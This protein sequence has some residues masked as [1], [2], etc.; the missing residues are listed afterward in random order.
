MRAFIIIVIIDLLFAA[1]ANAQPLFEL[2]DAKQSGIEFTNTVIETDSLHIMRYEYLYN[3]HGIG[4]GDFNNDGSPD[5]FISGNMVAPALYLNTGNFQFKNISAAAGIKY[6]NT[7]AT[8]VSIADVNGDSL[9]DIYVSHSGYYPENETKLSNELWINKGVVN[10]IPQFQEMA[11]E[12]GLDL[13][14]TQSTQAVFFDYDRDGDLDMF[15]VNHSNHTVNPFLNTRKVRS[16]PDMKHGNLLLRQDRDG[17]KIKFTDVT[18][19]AGIINNA[20]NFGLSAT[21]SDLNND[22]WPDIYTTSDYTET[23]CFYLN[24][25]N[26]T[27]TES[28]RKSFTHVSKYSMGS[29]IADYNN[30]GRPDVVTLDMLPEDNHRQKL[31]KGP[32]EYDQ[33]HLLIDSGYYHQQMR[34]M[35]HLNMGTDKDGVVRF[36]EIG[37]LA[38]ISNTDWSWAGLFADFDNDGWKDLLVTNGY[39]RDFTDLDFLKYTVADAQMESAKKGNF[40]FKTFDLVKKMPSNKLSSYV[41]RNNHDLRFEDVTKTWGL[42]DP[43][44]SNSAVYADLDN[45]GDL[46]IIIGRNNE[47]V[48]LY[49]NNA[50]KKSLRIK[51]VGSGYNTGA[52]GAKLVL[53]ANGEQQML[54]KYPVRGYQSSVSTELLFGLGS[55][56]QIDSLL[57]TWPDGNTSVYKNLVADS[58]Y[59]FKQAPG[60]KLTPAPVKQ[61]F[62]DVTSQ[63]GIS[64]RHI[65]NNFIDFK[66]EVLLPYQLSRDGPALAAADVNGDKLSD[67]FVG[68]AIGQEGMLYIQTADGR[69]NASPQT[70]WKDDAVSEDVNAIFFD[71]DGDGDNDLYV[72]SGGNEYEAGSPEYQDRLY[73][74]DGKGGFT[75]TVDALPVMTGSKNGVATGDYDGDGDMDLFVGGRCVAGSYPLPARSYLLQNKSANGKIVFEDVT[76]TVPALI[77]PGMISTAEWIDFDGDKFPE[78]VVSGD[79]MQVKLFKNNNG[80]LTEITQEAGMAKTSGM[81]SSL[82]ITDYD[83]DGDMDIVAGNSGTNLQFRA[84][85]EKPMEIYLTDVD[86]NGRL[87]P[88]I[89]YDIQGTS[90]PVASRDELLEQVTPLRKKFVYYKDYA[91]ATV[92]TILSKPAL[93]NAKRLTC[94]TLYSSVFIN[95]GKL[96]FT[97][98]ELP[99]E[100]QFARVNGIISEDFDGDGHKDM[101][102]AGNFYPYSVR[103]GRNDASLGV[104]MKGDR[105]RFNIVYPAAS[106]F[107]AGGD[108]RKMAVLDTEHGG[109]ILLARNDDTMQLFSINK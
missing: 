21:I 38:G 44:I 16:A 12:Y 6:N 81:W 108:I 69:F 60:F 39:L 96:H 73:M 109:L 100:A 7:W 13:P 28:L 91:D 67:F 15:L 55:A 4:V 65:E 30:D 105:H 8:G 25:K 33:Y 26:G 5:V 54:E 37:Q 62:G 2:V 77:E 70:A 19:A 51:L 98:K 40:N 10:G 89:C 64:F 53:F 72:V 86:K 1:M 97:M 85:A 3:G 58:G 80:R 57:I 107:F 94:E 43:A 74:N 52:I 49:K 76:K 90:Y 36:S 102:L 68:G 17:G 56:A 42:Y 20:L 47:P 88:L 106:G 41:F 103:L 29:D 84:S 23:D 9:Q 63:S 11:A 93:K 22:G 59:V 95:D 24:N 66:D 83:S 75:K 46:D 32:D 82:C 92:S 45:D 31:L 27:F 99:N 101:L 87:D 50:K 48:V 71:A 104:F 14:G 34:N 18:L 35:L 61:L 78:L 79:W